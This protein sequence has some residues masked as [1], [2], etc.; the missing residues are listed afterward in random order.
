MSYTSGTTSSGCC[1]VCNSC[2]ARPHYRAEPSGVQS[3]TLF[4]MQLLKH[5][6]QLIK[7]EGERNWKPPEGED[8]R[9]LG[10][11]NQLFLKIR[12]SLQRCVKLVSRGVTLARLA[13]AFKVSSLK[14]VWYSMLLK[15]A[16][17]ALLT[18][19]HAQHRLDRELYARVHQYTSNQVVKYD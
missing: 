5:L 3:C 11:A 17:S 19:V 15:L 10:S 9:V 4:A 1:D 7:E 18:A 13:G 14:S 2:S 12:A 16:N 8:N 6:D